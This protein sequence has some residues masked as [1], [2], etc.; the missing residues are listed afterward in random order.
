MIYEWRCDDCS[1]ITDV[2][3]S[4]ADRDMGPEEKCSKCGGT[5]HTRILS[6]TTVPWETLRDNGVFERLERHT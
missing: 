6:K 1:H 4:V 5:K 3:R 2:Q